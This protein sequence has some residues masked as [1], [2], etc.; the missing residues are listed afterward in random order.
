[1]LNFKKSQIVDVVLV[2]DHKTRDLFGNLN[3][4]KLLIKRHLNVALISWNLL[5][6]AGSKLIE[7]LSPQIVVV[8]YLRTNNQELINSILKKG[9][10]VIILDTEGLAKFDKIK[11]QTILNN[12]ERNLEKLFIFTWNYEKMK[13]WKGLTKIHKQN[14]F[15]TGNPRFDYYAP[16]LKRTRE[17]E[18]DFFYSLQSG[19]ILCATTYPTIDPAYSTPDEEKN[20]LASFSDKSEVNINYSIKQQTIERRIFVETVKENASLRPDIIFLVRPHPFESKTHYIQ[21]FKNISNI[22]V[23]K[24]GSITCLLEKCDA[25]FHTGCTSSIEAPLL[26]KTSFISTKFRSHREWPTNNLSISFDGTLPLKTDGLLQ[27]SNPFD[28]L[29]KVGLSKNLLGINEE[30]GIGEIISSKIHSILFSQKPHRI[31]KFRVANLLFFLFKKN[32]FFA[33][34]VLPYIFTSTSKSFK[35]I[36]AK[37][38]KSLPFNYVHFYKNLLFDNISVKST[39]Y[40][41]MLF[42][43]PIYFFR[44]DI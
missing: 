1:M 6:V 23:S 5:S 34:F 22:I 32:I 41:S 30:N 21:E 16:I 39:V 27:V 9:F 43:D 12:I 40:P 3:L 14:I 7:A 35:I 29:K 26:N 18:F 33:L 38:G 24:E 13:L 11:N 42:Q 2:N 15:V 25:L 36:K 17:L 31:S 10:Y 37:R 28:N 8:N 4:A 44:K 19:F 20:S